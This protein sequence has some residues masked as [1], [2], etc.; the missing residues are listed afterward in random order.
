V[1][2]GPGRSASGRVLLLQAPS[3]GPHIRYVGGGFDAYGYTRQGA[4]PLVMGRGTSHGWLQNVGMDDQVD[5]FAE[6]LN[7]QNRYQYW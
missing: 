3:D 6:K 2:I 7:P 4:G 1:V 5:V